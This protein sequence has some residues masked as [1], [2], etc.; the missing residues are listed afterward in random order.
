M[1][2]LWDDVEDHIE[3]E[4]KGEAREKKRKTRHPTGV[5]WVISNSYSERRGAKKERIQLENEDER[6]KCVREKMGVVS[7][8][9]EARTIKGTAASIT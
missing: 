3:V 6:L 8:D 7:T 4:G 2:F 1:A 5:K 9:E